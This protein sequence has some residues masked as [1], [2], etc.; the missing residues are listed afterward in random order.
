[1]NWA[2][3]LTV[4]RVLAV[5][6]FI[7]L[8]KSNYMFYA[9]LLFVVASATDALDG[10]IARKNNLVTNFGKIMDPL[11]DKIIV[12]SAFVLLAVDGIVDDWML[13]II[14]IREFV[15]SGLRMVAAADGLVISAGVTGKL[16]TITQMMATPLLMLNDWPF[17][18]VSDLPFGLILLWSCVSLTV[19]SGIE[20]VYVNRNVFLKGGL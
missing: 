5:P 6:I 18:I 3:R 7:G 12:I 10:Y 1:M 11:A 15:V 2:N 17:S 13:I 14:L 4:I 19:I 8:Y 16:K 9:A 20:Y